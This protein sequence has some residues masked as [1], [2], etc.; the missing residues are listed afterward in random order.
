MSGTSEVA[1][2]GDSTDLKRS[3]AVYD[4]VLQRLASDA[5]PDPANFLTADLHFNFTRVVNEDTVST[6][7]HVEGDTLVC[8]VAG[9]T[10]VLVP[11]AHSLA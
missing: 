4:E 7:R 5:D 6:V 3:F 8:L 11:N 2:K 10:S 9:S 1:P